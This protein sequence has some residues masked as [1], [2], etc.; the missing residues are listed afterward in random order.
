MKKFL[1]PALAVLAIVG[2]PTAYARTMHASGAW[3]VLM[4]GNFY[5]CYAA[6]RGATNGEIKVAGPFATQAK[7]DA[8]MGASSQCAAPEA[9]N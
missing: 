5:S 8:A 6:D 3:N 2:A 1:L 7:A 4:D 9:N